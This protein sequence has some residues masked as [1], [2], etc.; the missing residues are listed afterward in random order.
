MDQLNHN[1]GK[2]EL[3]PSTMKERDN[4]TKKKFK[5]RKFGQKYSTMM[6]MVQL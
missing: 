5:W 1:E 2:G 3:N 6:T 4:A